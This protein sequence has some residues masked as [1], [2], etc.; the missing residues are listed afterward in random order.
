M[1]YIIVWR[2]TH[3]EPHVNLDTYNFK[4]TY[5]SYES[6]KKD[7]EEILEQEN[8]NEPSLWYFDYKIYEE[9]NY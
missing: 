2:D 9:R 3:R 8:A 7:A 6:A 4:E 5:E 1:S